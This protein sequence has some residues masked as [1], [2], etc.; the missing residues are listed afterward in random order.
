MQRSAALFFNPRADARGY[1]YSCP[2]GLSSYPAPMGLTVTLSL[3][4]WQGNSIKAY[5]GTKNQVSSME[6]S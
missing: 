1:Q 6:I 5:A 2:P 4:G 3:A